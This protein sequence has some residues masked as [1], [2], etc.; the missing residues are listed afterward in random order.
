M[1]LKKDFLYLLIFIFLIGCSS[2]NYIIVDSENYDSRVKYLVIHYTSE[3]LED[4]INLLTTK[5]NHPVSSHYL[6]AED[7]QIYQL[8]SETKRAWHAGKSFWRGER[9]LNDSS[10]GIEIVNKSG[11]MMPMER[12]ITFYE[13]LEYCNFVEY[14]KVQINQL[15]KLSKEIIARHPRIKPY[16]IVAHS[17]IA[18]TRKIDPGPL[19]PWK[20]LADQGVGAWYDQ[21]DYISFQEIFSKK[22]PDLKLLQKK[23]RKLGYEIEPTGANDFQSISAIRSF[24]LHFRPKKY[25]GFFD[26]ETAAILYALLKKYNLM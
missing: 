5:T 19:F 18:P 23:L 6:I 12:L 25:D 13:I 7:A 26:V 17:D 9:G 21:I 15:I 1:Y 4:S 10:I 3:G 22:L 16:N 24:Q 14:P 20:D 2:N 11:C 8:V